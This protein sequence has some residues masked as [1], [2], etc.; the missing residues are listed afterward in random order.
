MGGEGLIGLLVVG[1]CSRLCGL[2]LLLLCVLPSFI[3]PYNVTDSGVEADTEGANANAP[4]LLLAQ[5][6]WVLA[7]HGRVVVAVASSAFGQVVVC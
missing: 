6:R 1:C 3:N 4:S 2:L 5:R 7:F